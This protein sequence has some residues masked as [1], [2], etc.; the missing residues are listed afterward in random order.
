MVIKQ[1][2]AEW[3]SINDA[4]GDMTTLARGYGESGIGQEWGVYGF[5]EFLETKVMQGCAWVQAAESA[6]YGSGRR[7]RANR[8]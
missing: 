1:L 3:V 7:P 5:H 8:I 6:F 4:F 2:R